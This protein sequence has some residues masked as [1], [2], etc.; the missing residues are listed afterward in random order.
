MWNICPKSVLTLLLLF[1]LAQSA[2]QCVITE[3]RSYFRVVPT[4]NGSAS[5]QLDR[6]SRTATPFAFN[7]KYLS[8]SPKCNF[9]ATGLLIWCDNVHTSAKT[10]PPSWLITAFTL[11]ALFISWLK[12]RHLH[13]QT[14]KTKEGTWQSFF[15]RCVPVS[16]FPFVIMGSG[17][18]DW[19]V[20][21]VCRSWLEGFISKTCR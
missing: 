3:Q 5:A 19:S 17:S 12:T 14:Q 15:F 9:Q 7:A 10:N 8:G 21:P 18:L 20:A 16:C 1:S 13:T 2:P 6:L 4:A 11:S